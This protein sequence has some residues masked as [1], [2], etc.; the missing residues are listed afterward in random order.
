MSCDECANIL[1][2]DGVHHPFLHC[3]VAFLHG[4]LL[5]L[6][7]QVLAFLRR[8]VLDVAQADLHCL[9]RCAAR[10]PGR[11]QQDA[12]YCSGHHF[13]DHLRHGR[14]YL[15][16]DEAGEGVSHAGTGCERGKPQHGKTDANR[17]CQHVGVHVEISRGCERKPK[18]R[19]RGH[20]VEHKL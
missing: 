11:E 13:P 20:D 5:D 19:S 1:C 8:D 4:R 10:R 12:D 15:V 6:R 2:L 14:L 9:S 16:Q 3:A 18:Q 7:R 17:H